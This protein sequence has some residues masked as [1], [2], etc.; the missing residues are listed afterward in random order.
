M[1]YKPPCTIDDIETRDYIYYQGVISVSTATILILDNWDDVTDEQIVSV[2][3]RNNAV[4][5]TTEDSWTS[6]QLEFTGN[7]TSIFADYGMV[8]YQDSWLNARNNAQYFQQIE[9]SES[10][11]NGNDSSSVWTA[12][13]ITLLVI[14]GGLICTI[15]VIR[16]M[17]NAKQ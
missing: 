2:A 5:D 8:K 9:D 1:V 12:T 15:A 3:I 17:T 7:L 13:I 16:I 14:G 10:T 4:I 11:D 6:A